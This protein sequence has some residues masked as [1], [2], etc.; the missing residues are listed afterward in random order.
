MTYSTKRAQEAELDKYL[1]KLIIYENALYDSVSQ[2]PLF[3]LDGCCIKAECKY[4][5]SFGIKKV[6]LPDSLRSEFRT[7]IPF[8]RIGKIVVCFCHFFFEDQIFYLKNGFFQADIRLMRKGENIQKNSSKTIQANSANFKT[9]LNACITDND[10][11]SHAD[12]LPENAQVFL[13]RP[14]TT[15]RSSSPATSSRS[16][17]PATPPKISSRQKKQR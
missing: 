5:G 13:A 14:A 16:S 4:L 3:I 8:Q 6:L 7:K 15:S 2:K 1:K 9:S 10:W 12:L 17:S 11:K